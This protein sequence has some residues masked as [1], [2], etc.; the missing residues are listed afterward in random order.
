MKYYQRL[1]DHMLNEHGLVLLQTEMD[2]II[3]ILHN[4]EPLPALPPCDVCG[5]TDVI[6]SPHMGR[7][8]NFCN[9][10]F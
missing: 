1:F 10:I 9:P 2:E 7:N 3:R 4:M 8:C 5:S 6:E